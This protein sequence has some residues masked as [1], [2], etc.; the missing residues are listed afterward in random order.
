[1]SCC[2][3][4]A[5]L[6]LH[7]A[8]TRDNEVLLA[9]R[10]VH[11]GLRQTDLSIPDIHCGAC[12]QR[13]ET[14]LGALDGVAGA[15]ANL[16]AKRVSILWRGEAPPPFIPTLEDIGYRAHLNDTASGRNDP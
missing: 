2:A 15:R 7:Q 10:P 9:S 12:L 14:A 11:D 4:G 13:I 6:Y 5:E 3:P 8:K 16:S 1:M